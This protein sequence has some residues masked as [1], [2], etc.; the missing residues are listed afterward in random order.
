[1]SFTLS[2]IPIEEHSQQPNMVECSDV[3]V[4][5]EYPICFSS[6]SSHALQDCY[7]NLQGFYSTQDLPQEYV[8]LHDDGWIRGE[9]GQLLLWI[10]I[11]MRSQFFNIWTKLVIPRGSAPELDL[12][13]MVHGKNWV[14]CFDNIA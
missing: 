4:N 5:V 2:C 12:S 3:Q 14:E 13:S 7:G 9:Y 1:M 11:P 8:K 10:P 6:V